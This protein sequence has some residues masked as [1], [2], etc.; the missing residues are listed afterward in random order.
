MEKY[1]LNC[2]EI[3]IEKNVNCNKLLQRK[4]M[5]LIVRRHCR[6]NKMSFYCCNQLMAGKLCLFS[7]KT[8]ADK[9]MSI[10]LQQAIE[11][12]VILSYTNL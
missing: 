9:K 7:W 5:P 6:Q 12:N 2:N 1:L 11:K 8:F 3:F 10:E 4:R